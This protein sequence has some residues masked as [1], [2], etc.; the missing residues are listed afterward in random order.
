MRSLLIFNISLF[1]LMLNCA[2]PGKKSSENIEVGNIIDLTAGFR[3]VRKVKLSEIA[4]S[5]TF[6]PF[7]TTS[8]SLQGDSQQTLI[9]F[10]K[11]YIFYY[12]MCYDWNGAYKGTIV[13][14]GQGM[15]EEIEGGKLVYNNNHFY[16][17]GRKLIEYDITGRPT[18]KI[19]RLYIEKE[20]WAKNH[21]GRS[22]LL[23][24]VGD[25]FLFY[26]APTTIYLVD[27]DFETVST[28]TVFQTD[29]STSNFSNIGGSKFVSNYKD[30]VLFYNFIND[31]IFHVM[32]TG[33]EPRW[34]VS[35]EH[36][37]RLPTQVM[38]D[39]F[40]L[41]RN[42]LNVARNGNPIDNT[43]FVRRI[44][45]KHKALSAYE[46]ESYVLFCMTKIIMYAEL[47]NLPEP[48]PYIIMFDKTNGNTIRTEDKGFVD[49][50][51]GMDYFY[52]LL[53][54]FDEKM[55]TY[56]W[57]YELLDYIDDCKAHGR[58]VNPKLTDLSKTID[59]EDN[60]IL[61]VAHL[62]KKV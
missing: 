37:L 9:D 19:K 57:P 18:G 13:K 36:P 61:I 16:S 54:V 44:D 20:D 41:I 10:S 60:P 48:N 5:I 35:F 29:S 53:G 28:A 32:D 52:P 33:I 17:K 45:G 8:E 1:F 24:V 50:L 39:A 47:R 46:T 15:F 55:I 26:D 11:N 2:E 30:M 3:N 59:P 23:S 25:N 4:D 49:D 43:D 14:K 12:K 21:I 6:I 40:I 34:I 7:E 31:T 42:L 62:K 27:R 56:I 22:S 51:L 58:E 38:L